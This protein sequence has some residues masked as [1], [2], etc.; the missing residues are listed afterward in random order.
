MN[1][2]EDRI[3]RSKIGHITLAEINLFYK[4]KS[5][6]G[7]IVVTIFIIYL[8]IKWKVFQ[9]DVWNDSFLKKKKYVH[10]LLLSLDFNKHLII[11]E[12]EISVEF[13]ALTENS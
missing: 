1:C 2:F 10:G 13:C 6:I 9:G 4:I 5:Q 7:E 11:W 8:A 12:N 3:L